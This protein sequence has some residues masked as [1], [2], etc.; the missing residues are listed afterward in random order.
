MSG[1]STANSPLDCGG[2]RRRWEHEGPVLPW[3]LGVKVWQPQQN[4]IREYDRVSEDP[5]LWL[6]HIVRVGQ[7]NQWTKAV[8]LRQ[9]EA[10]LVEAAELWFESQGADP[11]HDTWA[12]FRDALVTRFR[13]DHVCERLEE[14]L[15]S[16]WQH[17]DEIVS[18]YAERFRYLRVTDSLRYM[19]WSRDYFLSEFAVSV[20][21][22]NEMSR[23]N[24]PERL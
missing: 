13:E 1:I 4:C 24:G 7:A 20:R 10:N 19:L 21:I 17:R 3:F 22:Q 12:E 14:E 11:E 2:G 23:R 16:M 15:C 9:A 5:S 8:R 6:R 18:A